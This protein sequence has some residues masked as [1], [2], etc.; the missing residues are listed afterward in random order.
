MLH[1]ENVYKNKLH[2]NLWTSKIISKQFHNNLIKYQYLITFIDLK[3]TLL[4]S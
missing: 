2:I 3:Y 4:N 1:M